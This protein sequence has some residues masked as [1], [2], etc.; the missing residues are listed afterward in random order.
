MKPDIFDQKFKDGSSFRASDSFVRNFLHSILS[1]S[2][3][4]A[5]QAAQKLPKDW[6]CQCL[7]SFFRKSYIIKDKDIP[8]YLV[9]NF[10]QTQVTLTPGNR[11]SWAETGSKQ[12]ALVGMD[13]KRAF[14]L[15]VGVSADGTL[16]PFQ[17]IFV[18]KT[19]TSLPS[20]QHG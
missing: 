2:L 17:T 6:Q 9:V 4:K 1:W 15:V 13:E 20:V 10:D 7:H 14:T 8:I 3:R 11:M 19:T 12:V 16:L 18:G 5:M